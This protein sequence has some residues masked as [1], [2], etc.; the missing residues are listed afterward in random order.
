MATLTI[1]KIGPIKDVS[2]VIKRY[3][4]F[5]GLQ[6]SGKSTIAKIISNCTWMEKE[7]A[8][9]PNVHADLSYY[10][11]T[12]VSQLEEFHFMEGYL[13]ENSL[14]EYDSE[15]IHI[16]CKDLRCRI[17][18][19]PG[20]ENYERQKVLYIP[21]ERIIFSKTTSFSGNNNLN[22]FA[23]DWINARDYFDKEH[24]LNI[25]ALGISYYQQVEQ[26]KTVDKIVSR[27]GAYDIKL[28]NGSSGLQSVVPLA[29]AMQFYSRILFQDSIESKT[30]LPEQTKDRIDISNYLRKDYSE[31]LDIPSGI[32]DKINRLTKTKKT[33]FVIEE[34]ES[35]LY[36]Q[37]QIDLLNSIVKCS[38]S[39]GRGHTVT[40]TTHSPYIINQLN[41]LVKA[42][43][44]GKTVQGAE[45]D[46]DKLNVF[47][48]A[49]GVLTDLKVRNAHLIDTTM[50]SEP[51]NETYN[52]YENE[53]FD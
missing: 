31:M 53:I 5:I 33:S 39:E 3:N 51:L 43:D 1:K 32:I 7:I 49:D 40:I 29:S 50:L 21:A 14:L 34:P 9:H 10:E 17:S 15:F 28:V 16:S 35:N 8:T 12:F 6:S 4:F 25:L 2:F 38:L 13:N 23:L 11:D 27:N 41:L 46:F 26:G 48:V 42:H 30:L 36:P 52:M 22:S 44:K 37:S 19:K 20:V 18:V 24:K 47:F 45:M